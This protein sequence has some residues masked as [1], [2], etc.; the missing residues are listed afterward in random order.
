MNFLGEFVNYLRTRTD[1][2]PDFHYPAG[3][4]ALSVAL[5]TGVC[6]DGRSRD[7]YPN[8]WAVIIGPSGSGKSVPLDFCQDLVRMAGFESSLL[9]NSFSAEALYDEFERHSTRIAVYQ[10]FGGFMDQLGRE[11][12]QGCEKWLTDLYDT[13]E[14]DKRVLRAKTFNLTRPFLTIL[15]ASTPEWF[16][17]SFKQNTL[18]GGFLARFIF[19]PS[20]TRG[21]YVSDPGPR[22]RG[23]ETALADHLRVAGNLSGRMD[24]RG[25][26]ARYNEWDAETRRS[27]STV[28][29]E[30]GG[31]RSRMG[32]LC[33]KS[34]M[35]FHAAADPES[36]TVTTRDLENAIAYV[37]RSYRL[38]TEYLGERVAFDRDDAERLRVL[39]VVQTLGGV[40]VLRTAVLRKSHMSSQQLD[41]AIRT[42]IESERLVQERGDSGRGVA[43]SLPTATG[44]PTLRV[45][46]G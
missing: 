5:G 36:L 46:G 28:P 38:A 32:V 11:Y 37:E 30:F 25:V 39:E 33:K 10:E 26:L 40:R 24:F 9:A 23:L 31:L 34:A 13:P 16:A 21:A 7:V 44:N 29:P 42:L 35:L 27:V 15:G 4:A 22:N 1:A 8:I 2:P 20:E 12:M 41:R 3:L 18:R 14:S 17:A 6:T 19:C 45:V 43:Y